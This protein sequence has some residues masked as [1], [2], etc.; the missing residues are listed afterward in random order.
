MPVFNVLALLLVAVIILRGIRKMSQLTDAV[1]ALLAEVTDST[2]KLDSIETFIKGVPDLVAAAVATAL[3][4]A[5]VEAQTAAA[6]VDQARDAISGKVDEALAAI[7]ANTL[8]EPQ[9]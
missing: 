7:D 8:P 6:Q 2:T 5:N 3:E 9:P 1:A 4:N